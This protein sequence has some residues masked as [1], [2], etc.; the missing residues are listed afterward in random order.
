MLDCV[1]D[2][3][4]VAFNN[5]LALVS[6]TVGFQPVGIKTRCTAPEKL[7]ANLQNLIGPECAL[8]E[9]IRGT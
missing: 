4:R 7:L 8:V 3:I 2:T 6:R 5:A 1:D 9:Y